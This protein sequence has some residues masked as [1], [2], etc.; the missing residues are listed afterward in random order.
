MLAPV[1]RHKARASAWVSR[2]A[3][4]PVEDQGRIVFSGAGL[5]DSGVMTVGSGAERATLR[6]SS[7][8]HCETIEDGGEERWMLRETWKRWLVTW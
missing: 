7:V 8:V 3:F 6:S 1:G 4:A 5:T 2:T